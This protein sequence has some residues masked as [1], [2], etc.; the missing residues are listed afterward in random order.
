[1]KEISIELLNAT[2][3]Y[4]STRPFREVAGLINAL[5]QLEDVKKESK[6]K[7][8]VKEETEKGDK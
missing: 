6:L 3:E 8:T 1:M 2:L 5:S 4:L 7:N